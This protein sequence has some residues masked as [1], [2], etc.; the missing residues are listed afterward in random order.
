M[1]FLDMDVPARSRSNLN[2][3]AQDSPNVASGWAEADTANEVKI[4]HIPCPK[5]HILD[6]P[7][8]MLDQDVLCPYCETQFTLR[9]M[10]SVEETEKRDQARAIRE[11]RR[12]QLWLNWAIGIAA[13]VIL[14]I[15]VMI[16][17]VASK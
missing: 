11:E 1:P 6:T 3:L 12:G 4:W 7:D 5:G 8:D 16:A 2:E 13:V 14:G 10:K 17:L 15:I 9:K